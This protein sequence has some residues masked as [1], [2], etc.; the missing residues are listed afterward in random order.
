M[1]MAS[2]QPASQP[3]EVVG[4]ISKDEARRIANFNVIMT[5][6]DRLY[7]SGM[8]LCADTGRPFWRAIVS[9]AGTRKRVG[10]IHIDVDAPEGEGVTWHP[11][12]ES[13]S[14]NRKDG[15]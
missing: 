14:N 5:L 6:G 7:V 13:E 4:R 1:D 11:D 12:T 8:E 9:Q 3:V 10:E 15:A 2:T